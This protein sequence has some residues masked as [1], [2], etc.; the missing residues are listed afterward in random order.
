MPRMTATT[1]SSGSK[2][3]GSKSPAATS[4]PLIFAQG[5]FAKLACASDPRLAE[6]TASTLLTSSQ[7]VR[8]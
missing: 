3:L 8:T 6:S 4:P 1:S 7:K 2:N 5:N